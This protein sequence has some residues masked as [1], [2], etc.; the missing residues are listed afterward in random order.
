MEWNR[1]KLE[2]SI[3]VLERL[4]E[5]KT[6]YDTEGIKIAGAYWEPI[7]REIKERCASNLSR[8]GVGKNGEK[9]DGCI[10]ILFPNQIEPLLAECKDRLD[11]IKREEYDREL[12]HA[13]IKANKIAK[14][15]III[16]V[17]AATGL[18]Q[19]LL[20]WLYKILLELVCLLNN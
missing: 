8:G 19:Y 5:D 15:A 14:C 17:L 13:A 4:R 2:S 9:Y 11:V 3:A 12:K 20:K 1:R 18:P 7:K 16:S 10:Q 6:I